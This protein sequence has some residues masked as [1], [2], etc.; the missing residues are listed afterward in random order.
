VPRPYH[1]L[2]HAGIRAWADLAPDLGGAAWYRP[3]GNIELAIS[4][5]GRAELEARVCR[6]TEWGYPA[7]LI[8]TAE[9]SELEPALR[10]A[11]SR[12]TVAWFPGEGYV[13]T[14]PLIARLVAHITT[15]P[16]YR[17]LM[18]TP[19]P[20]APNFAVSLRRALNGTGRS[21]RHSRDN[22][23]CIALQKIAADTRDWDWHA[24]F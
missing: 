11:P 19:L 10:F 20:R 24:D 23:G 22:P 8:G 2:N 9:A 13:L 6:L 3:V 18:G 16:A 15:Y 17:V 14:E 21:G 4:D 1:D 7:R 12:G 5:T